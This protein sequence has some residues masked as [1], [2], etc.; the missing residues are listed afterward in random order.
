M[1]HLLHL[2][3]YIALLAAALVGCTTDAERNRMRSGLDSINAR[4]RTDQPFTPQD[5]QPYVQFF[6][7]HGN[8]NDRL[9][10]HYLL[11]RAYHEKGDAPMAL[12]CYQ[13]AIDCADTTAMN[14]KDFAQLSRVYAQMAEIFYYQGLYRE[15]LSH[16]KLSVHNA[17]K[18]KD[19]LAALM[20]YEQTSSL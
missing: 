3:I 5:V 4:N 17:W 13:H 16:E 9:L 2:I 14:D 20:S 7:S 18:G 12:E 6:D 1:R 8:A 10:A 19:T 11:G 15:Q